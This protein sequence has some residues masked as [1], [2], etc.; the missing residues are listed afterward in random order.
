MILYGISNCDTVRKARHFLEQ[1]KV[2]FTFHDFRKNGLTP[3][4]V[5]NWLT[6]VALEQL[7][8]QRSTSWKTLTPEQKTNLLIHQDLSLLIDMPTLIKRPVLE[9]S[10]QL[11]LGFDAIRYQNLLCADTSAAALAG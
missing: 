7:V 5:Q 10:N 3:Q 11:L 1:N 8:N 4:I 9:T 6:F 2:E